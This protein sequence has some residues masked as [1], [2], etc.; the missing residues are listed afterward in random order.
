MGGGGGVCLH[1]WA[2]LW[3]VGGAADAANSPGWPETLGQGWGLSLPWDGPRGQ[4]KKDGTP[5]LPPV[6]CPG[7]LVMVGL[8]ASGLSGHPVNTA[9]NGTE[10]DTSYLSFSQSTGLRTQRRTADLGVSCMGSA[11]RDL[12]PPEHTSKK[13]F[14]RRPF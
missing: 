10:G 3:G 13:K 2:F 11:I 5:G 14:P 7:A 9:I 12:Y 1:H 4:Q 6:W 8:E